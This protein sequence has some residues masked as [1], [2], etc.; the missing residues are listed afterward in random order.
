MA[1]P[2]GC[3]CGL[4][5]ASLWEHQYERATAFLREQK[6]WSRNFAISAE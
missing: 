4:T 3:C 5:R 1:W 2:A 6:A